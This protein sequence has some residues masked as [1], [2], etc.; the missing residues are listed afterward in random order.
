MKQ[1]Q[2]ATPSVHYDVIIVGGGQAGLSVSYHLQ[3]LGINHIVFEKNRVAHSWRADRWDSFCLVTPN[4]QCRLPDFP[5][6]GNDPQG[7]MLKD[8]IVEYVEA[9]AQKVNAPLREGVAV[10]RVCRSKSGKLEVTTSE[11]QF[12]ADHLVVA[13]GGYDIPIVPDYAHSLPKHITQV[14]S[15]HYR[16]P[17]QLPPGE[18]LVVGSGQSGVQIVEDLHLAGRK[19]HLAVGSAPRSP[20]L[21]RGRE[22]TEWLFDLGFYDLTVDRHPLGD[23]V[24]HKTNHYLTGRNGGHEIDLRKFALEGVHLYGSMANIRGARL[25]FRPD[26]TKNLDDADEIYVNIRNDI[27]RYIAEN[28]IDAP[29]EPPFRKF[30]EPESDPVSVDA[31]EAGITSIVWA[32]GFRPD[33]SWIELPAFDDRGHPRFRRGVTDVAGLYFI[34]LPWL[35]TWGSGRFLGIAE[36]AEYLA[37]EIAERLSNSRVGR[38]G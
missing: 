29:V 25:E 38:L 13:T 11:G 18:V 15:M 34:G 16:N 30:W 31:D 20:R 10:T 23:E 33:Y 21:Y 7:F 26:L 5:Y 14:H 24:R 32:I 3:K 17:A 1:H 12:S 37:V 28:N 19:V 8:E 9:F 6:Q 36:D 4:W 2:N 22:T 27:D 35:N